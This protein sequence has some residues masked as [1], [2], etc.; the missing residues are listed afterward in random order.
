[1][2]SPRPRVLVQAAGELGQRL[3]GPEIRA[4]EFAKALSTHYEV[5]IAAKRSDDGERDGIRVVPS[6]RRIMIRE[7]ARHDA[8]VSSCLPPYILALAPLHGA[9]TIADLYDPHEQ[10]LATLDDGRR[11]DRELR[12]RFA[13]QA[14]HLRSADVVVCASR[15]QRLELIRAATSVSADARLPDPAVLPFGIP[16]PPP[17][18][19]RRPLRARFP[20]IADTD[21]LI[22][23]WG[24]VWRWLDAETV[25]RA[26]AQIACVRNDVKLVITAGRPPDRKAERLFD[27]T[28]EVR[29]LASELGVLDR[30]VFFFD[31][32]IPYEARHEY[33]ADANLG[34]TLHHHAEEA[35]L[36]ARARYMDYLW[37]GLP[38]VL[39]RGDEMA[40]SFGDA[41]FATLLEQPDADSVARAV[42]ELIADSGG[43]GRAREA[44]RALAVEHQWSTIGAT[45]RSIVADALALPRRARFASP[46]LIGG[47]GAYYARQLADRLAGGV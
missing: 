38:C 32:W 33:L 25:V 36:A 12:A 23:W 43:L 37:A 27:A 9:V 45:L 3:V 30:S 22:L 44:G 8:I 34:V 6:S 35:R 18:S 24:S 46:S 2:Q 19:S 31:E 39:G 1:M 10:E 7:L 5:T 42:L 21:K 26:L 13:I 20:Q 14:L 11:R 4:L 40:E 41:G 29:A 17:E 15:R 16:D 28:D 47:T